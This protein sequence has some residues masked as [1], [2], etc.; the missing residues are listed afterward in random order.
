M[1]EIYTT[2]DPGIRVDEEFARLLP[3]LSTEE[4]QKLEQEIAAR[5]CTD[6]L[7]VWDDG[8]ENGGGLILL[9]GHHRF[10]ICTR[11]ERPFKV[12][13]ETAPK[14]RREAMEW[15]VEHQLARRNLRPSQRIRLAEVFRAKLEI[16][17]KERQE[18]AVKVVAEGDTSV[19]QSKGAV[20]EKIG[21]L[22]G[23]SPQQVQRYRYLEQHATPEELAALDAGETTIGTLYKK[24]RPSASQEPSVQEQKR[25]LSDQEATASDPPKME[26]TEAEETDDQ[27]LAK[28]P[29]GEILEGTPHKIFTR[30]ALDYRH[31]E[32]YRKKIADVARN[33]FKRGGGKGPW[34]YL[35]T[36][37]LK[38]EHPKHWVICPAPENGGCNGTG[39]YEFGECPKCHGAGYLIKGTYVNGSNR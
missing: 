35:L 28:L 12:R 7:T 20:K 18:H 37:F 30:D 16:E 33:R 39:A 24:Y 14:T 13:K 10:E 5:G 8:S 25:E 26:T 17:A 4:I 29:L 22:A 32:P 23:V 11:L 36:R 19:S 1:V 9:D 2:G 31:F 38:C 27:F 3:A 15:M 6:P 21:A 34:A